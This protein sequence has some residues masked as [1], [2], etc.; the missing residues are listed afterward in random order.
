[1]TSEIKAVR[2]VSSKNRALR[3]I[4]EDLHVISS[5]MEEVISNSNRA[6]EIGQAKAIL[7]EISQV[8]FICQVHLSDNGCFGCSKCY[9]K[10]VSS[11]GFNDF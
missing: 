8:K 9:F 11:K 7:S 3:A 6:D 1:M 10:I 4:C 2:W 5:H